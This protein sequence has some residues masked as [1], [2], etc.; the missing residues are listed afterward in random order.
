MTRLELGIFQA[1]CAI[2]ALVAALV[3]DW[4]LLI[5]VGLAAFWHWRCFRESRRRTV[6]VAVGYVLPDGMDE[7]EL[8][9]RIADAR[10]GRS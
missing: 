8:A 5:W 3:H 10:R 1:L 7:R 2:A 6:R 4:T 9:N